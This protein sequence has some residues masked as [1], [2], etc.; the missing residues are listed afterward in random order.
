MLP[1]LRYSYLGKIFSG[2]PLYSITPSKYHEIYYTTDIFD[3][4]KYWV[5]CIITRNKYA[6]KSDISANILS[7]PTVCTT[8]I[9]NSVKTATK[10]NAGLE[11]LGPSTIKYCPENNM[12]GSTQRQILDNYK[13][14]GIFIEEDKV[15]NDTN[16]IYYK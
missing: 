5:K 13:E 3:A 16:F 12:F 8:I 9:N 6:N 10:V 1:K 2:Y 7:R 4:I 14:I 15:P 11:D